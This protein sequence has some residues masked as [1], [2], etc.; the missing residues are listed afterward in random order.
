MCIYPF[1]NISKR[2]H[3]DFTHFLAHGALM[4]KA[5]GAAVAWLAFKPIHLADFRPVSFSHAAR[6]PCTGQ[7]AT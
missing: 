1:D 7:K 6:A 5:V 2:S 4:A 3:V